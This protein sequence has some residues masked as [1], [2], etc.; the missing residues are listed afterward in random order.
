[1]VARCEEENNWHLIFILWQVYK[2]KVGPSML[3]RSQSCVSLMTFNSLC[4]QKWRT[5][6]LWMGPT[7]Y[8]EVRH[9]RNTVPVCCCSASSAPPQ[10]PGPPPAAADVAATLYAAVLLSHDNCDRNRVTPDNLGI[11]DT[12]HTHKDK[13]GV[14]LWQLC[15]H[16]NL[17]RQHEMELG[18]QFWGLFLQL[19]SRAR[20]KHTRKLWVDE[21][22]K[23][24]NGSYIP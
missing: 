6:A 13:H 15:H 9:D 12:Q 16:F 4:S 22:R 1:M 3:F 11:I 23:N 10:Q 21:T 20:S 17:H 14:S 2:P 24:C 18:F 19:D 7:A 8:P 5:T